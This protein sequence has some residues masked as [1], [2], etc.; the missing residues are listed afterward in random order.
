MSEIYDE[1]EEQQTPQ[2]FEIEEERK[3]YWRRILIVGAV[4]LFAAFYFV[5]A[6]YINFGYIE[7]VAQAPFSV[8]VI[9][10]KEESCSVSPCRIKLTRGEKFIDVSKVGFTAEAVEEEVILWDTKTIKPV[11]K[12]EPYIR[13]IEEISEGKVTS[14]EVAYKFIYDVSHNNYA[15]VKEGDEYNLA[16]SYFGGKLQKPFLIGSNS[17]VLAV[18]NIQNG[19]AFYINT[20]TKERKSLAKPF[21]AV[22]KASVSPNGKYFILETREKNIFAAN[23]SGFT[24][25]NELKEI[26]KSYWTLKNTLVI[27]YEQSITD[28]DGIT[29]V[30]YVFEEY[31]PADLNQR[32]LFTTDTMIG[33]LAPRNIKVSD[34]T[35]TVFFDSG[36]EKYEIVF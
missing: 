32:T 15:I 10:E 22:A 18:E 13:K 14:E 11:L 16:V 2:Q 7:V 21:T 36:E 26:K 27:W 4:I 19:K 8:N 33:E 29:T 9:G 3:L 35:N 5:W 28:D 24:M 25:I 23:Q 34:K 30:K 12:L 1:Q 6:N 20:I 31:N 17:A